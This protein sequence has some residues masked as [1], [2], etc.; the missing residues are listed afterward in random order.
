MRGLLN[1]GMV[2]P[3]DVTVNEL[4]PNR[5]E[6]LSKTYSVT[7][8]A[9][10]DDAIEKADLVI[11]AVNPPQVPLVTRVLKPLIN[12]QTIILSIAAG[13]TIETLESQVGSDKK[14]VRVTPNTLSQSGSGYSAVC[15]N[16]RCNDQ[17][18]SFITDVLNALGQIM[19]LNEDMFNIFSGFSNVGPLW[20][21]KMVESLTDAGVYVGFS[22]ADARNIVL[23]NMMGVAAVLDETGEHPAVKVDQMASPGGVTIEA[24]RVLQQGG[25]A[26]SLMN[27]AIASVDKVN[28]IE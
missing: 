12:E 18:K 20:L 7:A 3:E 28:S 1:K 19:Y 21:Y 6:Y 13:V 17:D 8:I 24:L 4:I 15:M 16:E 14:V 9:N 27:S 22:R 5:C 26:S 23:K 25:F 11:I 2:T 10:A